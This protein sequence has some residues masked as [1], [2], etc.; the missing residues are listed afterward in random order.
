MASRS[1]NEGNGKSLPGQV[2]QAEDQGGDVTPQ[3]VHSIGG[4]PVSPQV[5]SL[6]LSPRE[7]EEPQPGA[8]GAVVVPSGPNEAEPHSTQSSTKTGGGIR[9]PMNAL[10]VFSGLLSILSAVVSGVFL[11]NFARD[12]VNDTVLQGGKNQVEAVAARVV[13]EV[14]QMER[15]MVETESAVINQV[16]LR[17]SI[18]TRQSGFDALNESIFWNWPARIQ[19]PNDLSGMQ[20]NVLYPATTRIS[21]MS[22]AIMTSIYYEPLR[23]GNR[24]YVYE[25][26][27]PDTGLTLRR[28]R[29]LTRVIID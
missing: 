17:G 12:T 7:A 18:P 25:W 22:S 24:S 28:T 14:E 11:F 9:I 1:D 13:P 15:F 16:R 10:F 4:D 8:D 19:L 2:A 21:Q 23:D 5:L 3:E 29:D 27:A 6:P 20:V 26:M